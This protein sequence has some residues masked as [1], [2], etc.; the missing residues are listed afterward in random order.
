MGVYVS[1]GSEIANLTSVLSACP[2]PRKIE[3]LMT[4]LLEWRSIFKG[5]ACVVNIVLAKMDY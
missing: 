5:A 2:F 1:R 3:R 4:F